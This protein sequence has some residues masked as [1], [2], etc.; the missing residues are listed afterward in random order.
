MIKFFNA[1]DVKISK[2][3]TD[4]DV[5]EDA[6]DDNLFLNTWSLAN[7]RKL[8]LCESSHLIL[9]TILQ[10]KY[11]VLPILHK[12]KLE[13]REFKNLIQSQKAKDKI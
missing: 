10:V 13:L 2:T 11:F 1:R 5:N 3:T 12:K 6:A 9:K 4:D 8:L 7:T